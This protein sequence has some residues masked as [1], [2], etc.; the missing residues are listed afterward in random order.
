MF[1]SQKGK[2][3]LRGVVK[4]QGNRKV[5]WYLKEGLT[6]SK[7]KVKLC[8]PS[9]KKRMVTACSGGRGKWYRCHPMSR[10]G[11]PEALTGFIVPSNDQWAK[12]IS[13]SQGHRC[14]RLRF[15]FFDQRNFMRRLSLIQMASWLRWLREGRSWDEAERGTPGKEKGLSLKVTGP[16]GSEKSQSERAWGAREEGGFD[17]H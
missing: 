11:N 16:W 7:Q 10:G 2:F 9:C 17:T 1:R 12:L 14:G 13:A 3:F 8:F 5:S 4:W 6:S 15:F